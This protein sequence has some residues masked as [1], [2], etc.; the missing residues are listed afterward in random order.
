M[1]QLILAASLP[2]QPIAAWGQAPGQP[3]PSEFQQVTAA[4]IAD[5]GMLILQLRAQLL[6]DQRL[7]T[8]DQQ[9]IT[10]LQRQLARQGRAE[11]QGVTMRAHRANIFLGIFKVAGG[12]RLWAPMERTAKDGAPGW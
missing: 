5:Q 7:R 11:G 9:Q 1:K 3:T 8:A 12:E 10:D 2:V 6:A 4:T